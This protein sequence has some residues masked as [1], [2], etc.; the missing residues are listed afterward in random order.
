MQNIA[1]AGKRQP[2]STAELKNRIK[3]TLIELD[4][5]IYIWFL[6]NQSWKGRCQL[7]K[8]INKQRGEAGF[9]AVSA[10]QP[11]HTATLK[12]VSVTYASCFP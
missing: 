3:N 12:T 9:A 8:Q 10:E 1:R 7:Q 6:E 11:A 5:Y 2:V 4:T